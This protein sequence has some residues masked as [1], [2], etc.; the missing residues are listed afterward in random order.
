MW[1]DAILREVATVTFTF[2]C[3]RIAAGELEAIPPPP[4]MH[5]MEH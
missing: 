4:P 1:A 3:A 5:S 2:V